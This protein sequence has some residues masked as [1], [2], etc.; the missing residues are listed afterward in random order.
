MGKMLIVGHRGAMAHAPENS[1]EG[2][3]LAEEIG[4]DEIELDVRL[5]ADEELFLLHDATLDRTAGEDSARDL[6]PAG[7]MTLAQLRS[8]VLDSGTG[9][10]TLGEM[11]EAT[12]T[13]IQLEIK[14]PDTVPYLARYFADH[15]DHAARTQ[16]TS[17]KEEPLREARELFPDVPRGIIRHNIATAEEF[18]GGWQ[19]LVEHTGA[20]RICIGFEGLTADH[21]QAFRDRG[22]ELHLW[23]M[24][25]IENMREAVRLG[26]DGTT[27]DDPAL[28]MDWLRQ[29]E[30][31]ATSA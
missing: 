23:P 4:V 26:A 14:A 29:V 12:S 9:V 20:S 19:A 6:G 28:A 11:Y 18:E 22:L 25:S 15:P 5:S 16:L 24:R 1:L 17:F 8:V 7:E 27:A 13:V 10:V 2:Y 3:A 30:S 31:E 21:V